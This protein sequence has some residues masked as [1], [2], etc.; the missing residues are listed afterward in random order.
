MNHHN[1]S[2]IDAYGIE[3]SDFS[4][5]DHKALRQA[6]NP[7]VDS[8]QPAQ[9]H[10]RS[11]RFDAANRSLGLR[12]PHFNMRTVQ[13]TTPAPAVDSQ[14][15]NAAD[16]W[17]A[18]SIVVDMNFGGLPPDHE[19]NEPEQPQA[20]AAQTAVESNADSEEATTEPK[21][22]AAENSEPPQTEPTES[23]ESQPETA[24]PQPMT[25]AWEV[26]RF[27]WPEEIDALF[28]QQAD[29]FD[30]AG[31]KLLSA[32]REGLKVLAVTSAR[33][34]EGATIM[35]MCL[36]RAA[37]TAGAKVVLLD[38]NF[39]NAELGDRLGVDFACGWQVVAAGE[40]PL[41]EAAI[42]AVEENIT[43]LAS[44]TD[45]SGAVNSLGEACV[46]ELVSRAL[47]G[48]D[49]LII[50]AGQEELGATAS[51]IDG[52]IVVRDVRTT[53]EQRTLDLATIL[54]S[55]GVKAVGVAENFGSPEPQPAAAAA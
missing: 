19:S 51:R 12:G 32:S 28:T 45:N 15:L 35:A 7:R 27:R 22:P 24:A 26:D 23:S 6:A 53:S 9:Q 40:A 38:G 43:L 8:A 52:A 4:D 44:K 41:S 33:S 47:V 20:S 1:D 42:A 54:K 13:D 48:S 34:G 39:R 49:L 46:A 18:D 31:K 10:A 55:Q 16:V 14:W 37:A 36:A 17:D 5:A 25:P 3:L 29:Y 11:H 2:F 30:Y 50:D 21:P